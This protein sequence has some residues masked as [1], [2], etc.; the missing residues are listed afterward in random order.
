LRPTPAEG[1][2]TEIAATTAVRR[3]GFLPAPAVPTLVGPKPD[4][5]PVCVPAAV[6]RWHH[7]V[8]S[9]PVLEDEWMLTVIERGWRTDPQL[10]PALLARHRRDPVRRAR[11]VLAA[12]P[13]AEWLLEHVPD[14][15]TTAPASARQSL[16]AETLMS[17]P[18]LPIPPELD[19]LRVRPG[20]EIGNFLHGALAAGE[21]GAP[22]RAV[23]VNVLARVSVEALGPIAGC[24]EA[25]D[26]MTPNHG[27]AA[28]LADLART[29]ASML[30]E[31]SGG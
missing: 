11:V 28:S 15:G 22:N 25:V 17:L 29:R 13:I 26:P 21:L 14:M 1:M 10:V 7:V 3:A 4:P 23:L 8:A 20:D 31:L 5:R 2:L 16:D 27:L 12:G 30:D 19:A 9:W 6:E 24:L 18:A